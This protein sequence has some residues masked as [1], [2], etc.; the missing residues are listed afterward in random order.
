MAVVHPSH[1]QILNRLRR[2]DGHLHN[3]VS[4]LEHGKPC[5]DIVQQ[6]QAVEKAIGAA[7]RALIH[8]HLDHCLDAVTSKLPPSHLARTSEFKA[9]TKYL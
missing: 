7:K 4:M 1:P 9:I 6:L 2:A 3:V 5:L 8:D